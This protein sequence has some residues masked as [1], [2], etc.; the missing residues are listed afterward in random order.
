MI[1]RKVNLIC[2]KPYCNETMYKGEYIS[3][4]ILHQH[5]WH[6]CQITLKIS[7]GPNVLMG[8]PEISLWNIALTR[9]FI[10]K[11]RKYIGPKLST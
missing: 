5:T 1:A 2:I 10:A 7:G 4:D 3:W 9:T 8:L 6:A 11:A